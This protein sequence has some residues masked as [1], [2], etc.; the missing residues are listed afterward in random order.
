MTTI[1]KIA[2]KAVWD[3]TNLTKGLLTTR[4]QFTEQKKILT[5]LSSPLDRYQTAQKN[6]ADL[7]AKFPKLLSHKAK[8]EQEMEQAYLREAAAADQLTRADKRRL[9]ELAAGESMQ[10]RA[11]AA[12]AKEIEDRKRSGQGARLA[13]ERRLAD[14]KRSVAESQRLLAER[15][16][17]YKAANR[18]QEAEQQRHYKQWQAA[19]RSNYKYMDMRSDRERMNAAAG[20]SDGGGGSSVGMGGVGMLGRRFVPAALAVGG[21]A[22]ARRTM[23][24]SA[25][26]HMQVERAQAAFTQFSGSLEASRGILQNIRD[27]SADTGVSFASLADGASVMMRRGFD[28]DE[29]VG[30]MR[31]L[32]E[33]TGGMPHQMDR[34]AL[35]MGQIRTLGRLT[36]EEL[37]QLTEAGWSPMEEL[38]KQTGK[39]AGELRK[40]MEAGNISYEMVAKALDGATAAGGRYHGF[41]EKIQGTTV[42]AANRSAAAWEDAYARMG[43]SLAPLTSK[44]YE[45]WAAMAG[46]VA[47]AAGAIFGSGELAAAGD[48]T[49][50]D[51]K[52]KARAESQARRQAMIEQQ[53][54]IMR[55]QGLERDQQGAA[56]SSGLLSMQVD[57]QKSM[58]SEADLGRWERAYSLLSEINQEKARLELAEYGSQSD[59]TAYLDEQ[60]KK[61]FERLEAMRQQNDLLAKRQEFEE[62]NKAT[63][64]RYISDDEQRIRELTDMELARRSGAMDQD[65]FDRAS[66]ELFNDGSSRGGGGLAANMR[67]GSQEAYQFMAGVQDR[68]QRQQMQQH[69]EAVAKQN[70]M[71]EATKRVERAIQEWEPMGVAG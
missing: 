19:H 51:P 13:D 37:N 54:E 30:R 42:G 70:A 16:R 25:D 1:S 23:E 45:F 31:Q 52:A 57:S 59:I 60:S 67:Q 36:A 43:S 35:A 14:E 11:A 66:G 55:Q 33:V 68:Q 40:E 32:A 9:Q 41:L 69:K 10:R 50:A 28:S 17:A 39:S 64:E 61:E 21:I 71:I 26:A 5:A 46:D 63:A 12:R 15:L 6:L 4:Q 58:M 47:H 18:A 62:R 65:T 44:W 27:L 8:L 49:P 7:L 56:A 38:M 20:P 3:S 53:N 48:A 34:M 29:I 24:Q 22:M 2:Y